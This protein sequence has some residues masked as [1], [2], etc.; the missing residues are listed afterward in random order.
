M[1]LID[2]DSKYIE[3]YKKAYIMALECI[4]KIVKKHDLMFMNPDETDIVKS[5]W[6]IILVQEK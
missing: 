1:K 4:E 3:E 5:F 2:A 6:K